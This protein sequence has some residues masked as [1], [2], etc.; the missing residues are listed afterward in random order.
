MS[1]PKVW[2]GRGIR[3]LGIFN[4]SLCAKTLWRGMNMSNIWC[5][6]LG[7]LMQSLLYIM[8]RLNGLVSTLLFLLSYVIFSSWWVGVTIFHLARI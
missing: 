3:T 6:S 1:M 8:H 5:N 4:I 2:G 7:S